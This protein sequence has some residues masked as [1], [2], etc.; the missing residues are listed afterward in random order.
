MPLNYVLIGKRIKKVRISKG[1]SQSALAEV[2]DVSP[3]T[4]SYIETGL[5]C[6]NLDTFVALANALSVTADELIGENLLKC[7]TTGTFADKEVLE[8]F[9]NCSAYE[10]RI[11]LDNARH[12]KKLLHENTYL[13]PRS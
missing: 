1:L 6:P 13:K 12:L 8:I 10:R 7:R 4:V 5:T 11:L 3:Q 9:Q 2:A